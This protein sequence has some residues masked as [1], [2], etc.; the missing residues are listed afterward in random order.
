M[1]KKNI[2][3]YLFWEKILFK[4]LYKIIININYI[5]FDYYEI[6]NYI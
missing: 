6:K 1:I 4:L 2:Y 5:E 3:L